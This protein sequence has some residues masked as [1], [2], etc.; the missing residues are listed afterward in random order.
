MRLNEAQFRGE[1]F[2]EWRSD[3]RGNNDLLTLT[4]PQI[5]GDIHR[6]YLNAGA[7]VISTNTF[8]SS[9]VSQADY[10]MESL[11]GELNLAAARLARQAA[12]EVSAETGAQRFV[13]GAL[14]PTS[15]TASLSPDVN[16][17]GFRNISF[18]ELVAGYTIAVRALVEGGV[19]IILIETVFDTL[20]AKAALFAVR[21]GVGPSRHRSAHHRVGHD[22][23]RL[24][25]HPVGPDHGGLLEFDPARAAG[26]GRIELRARRQA[27]APPHRGTGA[28]RR[29]L[30]LRLPQRGTAECLRR[31]R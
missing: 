21:G 8:N 22:H 11:V 31:V 6:E 28:R 3:L 30:C 5:I 7:D 16:D 1:R 17:P 26:R 10:G 18:D 27:V 24:G 19:D 15:R 14:G 9:P 12:D 25:Q 23:R 13:A 4:Q 2:A 29:H 20:N